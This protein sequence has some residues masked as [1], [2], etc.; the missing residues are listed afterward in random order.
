M[1]DAKS[2]PSIDAAQKS[3]LGFL[4]QHLNRVNALDDQ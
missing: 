2:P 4:V 1:I 3:L